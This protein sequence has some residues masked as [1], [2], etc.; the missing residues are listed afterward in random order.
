MN[1][2]PIAHAMTAS[3][4][5]ALMERTHIL[6]ALEHT[7]WRI[8]GN[9]GAAVILGLHPDTLRYRMKKHNIQRPHPPRS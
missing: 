6:A 8:E 5:P 9:A 2:W 1:R 3:D 4:G 7:L